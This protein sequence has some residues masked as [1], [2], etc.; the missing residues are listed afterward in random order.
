MADPSAERILGAIEL[1]KAGERDGAVGLLSDEVRLGAPSGERWRSV[2]RLAADIGEIEIA[3][4]AARRYAQTE[5]ARLDRMLYYATEL[6]AN[7]RTGEAVE[8]VARLPDTWRRHPSVLLFLAMRE[9]EGGEFERAIENLREMSSE[10][11]LQAF[12]A[13]A[14]L[15]TFQPGDPDLG[16]MERLLPDVSHQEPMLKA[17]FL[18]CLGKAYDD[19]GE[20]DRA[21]GLF[22]RSA[23]I[24]RRLET[25]DSGHH[26]DLAEALIRDFTAEGAKHLTPVSQPRRRALFATGLPRSGTTLIE[27]I[28]VSHSQI[29]EGAEVNFV[30]AS[31]SGNTFD[32]SFAGAMEYQQRFAGADPWGRVAANYFRMLEMRFRTDALV[33]NKM[34]LLS[35]QMGLILHMLPEARVV[36]VRRN[37]DDAALSCF[38]TFFSQPVAWSW[39]L[40]EIGRCFAVEDRLFA[41]WS[42]QFPERILPVSYEEFVQN[43]TGGIPAIMDFVGLPMEPQQRESHRTK[44]RVHTASVRQVRDPISAARVGAAAAYSKH[45]APFRDAY[46]R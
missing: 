22:E 1:L 32:N 17:R 7:G 42:E 34:P 20:Y 33:V 4:E 12:A 18:S 15:K 29:A 46:E 27:Q 45:L 36:W 11:P 13:L 43:P 23:A 2:Q 8:Q 5:P 31:L 9:A 16:A 21:W 30:R 39:S 24:R 6:A 28:L 44:R 3:L 37:P 40:E 14:M 25:W 35:I 19:C 26:E 38:R 10:S 41:H